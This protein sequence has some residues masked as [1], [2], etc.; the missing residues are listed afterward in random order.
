MN[1]IFFDIDGVLNHASCR[2]L[3]DWDIVD[4]V[5]QMA[6]DYDAKLVMSS[7]W[8]DVLINPALYNEPDKAFV[9]NL[10]N[11]L[12]DLFIGHTPDIDDEY[13]EEEIQAWLNEHH[14][15]NKFVILDD[16]PFGFPEVFPENFVQT[17]GYNKEGFSL[18]NEKEARTILNR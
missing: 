1:I 5:K 14:E 7:S 15:V 8:K 2:F 10:I 4:R 9:Y 17:T 12:G 11:D 16:L 13:R 18:D 3:M 6:V